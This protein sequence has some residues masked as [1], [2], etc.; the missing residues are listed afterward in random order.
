MPSP[1]HVAVGFDGLI[2]R[3]PTIDVRPYVFP[4]QRPCHIAKTVGDGN[5]AIHWKNKAERL[6]DECG[7][8]LALEGV[9]SALL[10]PLLRERQG[11]HQWRASPDPD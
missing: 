7:W 5:F 10:A 6:L 2:Q 9:V 11:A 4:E 1:F 3:K 8:P